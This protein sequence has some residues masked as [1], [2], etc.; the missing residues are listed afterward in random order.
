MAFSF[1]SA[2]LDRI[3]SVLGVSA[4]HDGAMARLELVH[5]QSGRRLAVEVH[6]DLALPASVCDEQPGNL[7]SVYGSSSFMQL[8]GCT[9]FL[10]SQELGEVI[11]FAKRNGVTSGLV[12]E[13]EAGCSLFA[14]VDD[15][16][17]SADFTLLPSEMVMSSISLSMTETIF[18]DLQ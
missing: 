14:N 10:A 1:S 9:G 15:R 3:A 7:V 13:R 4:S 18:N 12:I 8:Q 17:L 2:D 11:F 16:L 5:E 6:I